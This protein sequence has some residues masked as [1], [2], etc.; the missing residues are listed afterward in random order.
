LWSIAACTWL[1]YR[2][3]RY[4]KTSSWLWLGAVAGLSMMTKYSAVVQ[5][6]IFL[7]FIVVHGHWR[8]QRVQRGVVQAAVVFLLVISPHVYW[9]SHNQV[10]AFAYLVR[11]LQLQLY[12]LVLRGILEVTIDH[13]GRISPM[14][15]VRIGRYLWQ[16]R[17][18]GEDRGQ[19]YP[20]EI[21]ALVKSL[22]L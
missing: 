22:L 14:F 6:A 7:V 10:A 17:I 19:S 16:H 2:A 3:L 18:P 12:A 15:V 1:F 20:S 5:F 11:P 21:G 4:A 8:D 13:L 9:P